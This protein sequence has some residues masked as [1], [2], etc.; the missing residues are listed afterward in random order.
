SIPFTPV[1]IARCAGALI[2][3]PYI[4]SYP[5][6]VLLLISP[7]L[8]NSALPKMLLPTPLPEFYFGTKFP[9]SAMCTKHERP[10]LEA[11]N[12]LWK[13]PSVD[14]I[15]VEDDETVMGHEGLMEIEQWMDELGI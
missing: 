4:S 5:A 8:A 6:T 11:A 3:Q 13:D 2:A 9:C 10:A 15:G 14:K 7:P 12:R 1:I